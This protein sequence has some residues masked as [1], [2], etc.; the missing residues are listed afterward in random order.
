MRRRTRLFLASKVLI[1]LGAQHLCLEFLIHCEGS[2][3]PDL[4]AD[5]LETNPR[6]RELKKIRLVGLGELWQ[7]VSP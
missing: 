5:V 4:A 3:I 2:L 1:F 7:V 6:F